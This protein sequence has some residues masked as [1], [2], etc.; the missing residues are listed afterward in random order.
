MNAK[1]RTIFN[2]ILVLGLFA[3]LYLLSRLSYTLFHSFADI[4]CV[5]IATIVFVIIW[6]GRH[7]LDNQYYFCISVGFLFFAFFDFL[8]LLGN[9]G[10]GV[11]SEF[12]NMGPAFYIVSRY[13]LS[14]SFLVAPLLI[15]RKVRVSI[16]FTLYF[17]SSILI[18]LS[19]FYWKNFPVTYIEGTG[20]T[21]FKIVSDYVINFFFLGG[22]G[23]LLLNRHAFDPRVLKFTLFSLIL[24]IATG[25]S[26]TLYT[27]P[28][29]LTNVIGHFLQIIS[30][31]LIYMTFIE[32]GLAKP[33]NLLFRSLSQ[34]NE[35]IKKLNT[36]LQKA[37]EDLIHSMSELER[38]DAALK[39]SEA[40][41]NSLIKF[42][43][44]AIFEF[45]LDTLR[46]T[47]VNEELCNISGY[48]EEEL[49]AINPMVLLDEDSAQ[50]FSVR[51]S[52]LD[53]SRKSDN[54]VEYR[55][56]RKDGSLIFVELNISYP[57]DK[58]YT[59]F[60]IG[61][62]VTE[63]RRIEIQLK[64]S[65]ERFRTLSE[66]SLIGV[67]VSS[68]E[69][70]LVYGN[71]SYSQL[72]GYDQGELIGKRT[73][74]LY[75]DP[76]DRTAWLSK[77]LKVGF[78]K[79][80]ELRLKKKDGHLIRVEISASPISFGGTMA[81]METIRD[82]SERKKSDDVLKR[83]AT[84]LEVSNKEL[85]AF[86]YSLSHDLRAPLRSLD[87]FSQAVLEDY[88]D[89]LDNVGKDYLQRIRG[90]TQTMAQITEGMLKLSEVIRYEIQW[91][92][93]SLSDIVTLIA[94]GLREKDPERNVE[95]AITPG[96]FATG[97][98]SLLQIALY[99][100]MENAWKF[101]AKSPQTRIEFTSMQIEG[102]TVYL[103]RDNG[104]GFDMQYAV[105]MFLPFQRLHTS[106][107]AGHGIG[108]ATVQ[109]VIL[110][111]RGRIWAESELG[112]GSTFYFTLGELVYNHD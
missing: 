50:A 86:A 98:F 59:A 33:Q 6:S 44:A 95:F 47:S 107:F 49:Y 89:L 99:N 25:I 41:A 103:V 108:L 15:N 104:I 65:E 55:I 35:E 73:S 102:A 8:H 64:E 42:A 66:T 10:M 19:I 32:T 96:I 105:K 93:D 76:E 92:T 88:G 87:G 61:Y 38:A 94:K 71:R 54:S 82:I 101:T 43:P 51:L 57:N 58:T 97:D 110:R 14:L 68:D 79:D 17:A 70:V 28:F 29:G 7:H 45:D 74:D 30:F 34:S 78:I 36:K 23:L 69:G 46:F 21:P 18:L 72:L 67:G 1:S 37:N 53:F 80:T 81:V 83:Y 5:F 2:S 62:D 52:A 11:F 12:G 100:L 48:N 9:K 84:E 106:G 40:Q 109:R 60:V 90:A 75:W 26:F 77:F 85:E 63:R 91:E 13:I 4:I 31:Y 20:L 24:F 39:V 27:D 22:I 3:A 111:H 112:K 56:R 16:L